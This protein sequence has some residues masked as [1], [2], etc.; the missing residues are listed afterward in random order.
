MFATSEC[1][2]VRAG[3]SYSSC[4]VF[5][6][7]WSNVREL[8][9]TPKI[10]SSSVVVIVLPAMMTDSGSLDTRSRCLVP[11]IDNFRFVRV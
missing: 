9:T 6:T 11:S 1:D 2:E 3:G 10:F 8:Y 4:T 5:S 7:C